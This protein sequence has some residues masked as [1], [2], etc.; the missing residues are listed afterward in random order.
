MK[1]S[2]GTDHRG[3]EQKRMVSRIA[4]SLGHEVVDHGTN[5]T[6]SCDYPD[7]AKAL[8]QSV[9]SGNTDCGILICGTGIGMSIAANKVKGVRAAVCNNVAQSRLSRQHN[10]ANVLCIPG[11]SFEES[12]VKELVSVWLETEFEGGR[13]AR[14]VDKV[15]QMEED[16]GK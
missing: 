12:A 16:F 10:D 11:D 14:R 13:H 15:K 6:E 1:I 8:G 7:I 3:L 5:S 2:V 4:E 9:V